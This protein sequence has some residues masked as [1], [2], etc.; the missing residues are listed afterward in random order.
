MEPEGSLSHSQE[1]ANCPYPEMRIYWIR[2]RWQSTRGSPPAGR[3]G[4]ELTTPHRKNVS[5]YEPSQINI[6]I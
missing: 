4:K 5:R 2:I 6:A 3:L 1:P